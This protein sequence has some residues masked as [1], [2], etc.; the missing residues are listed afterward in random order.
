VLIVLRDECQPSFN[1][2]LEFRAS[3]PQINLEELDKGDRVGPSV[4]VNTRVDVFDIIFVAVIEVKVDQSDLLLQDEW[5]EA[6]AWKVFKGSNV[7]LIH[8]IIT[9][10]LISSR[11]SLYIVQDDHDRANGEFC[12]AFVVHTVQGYCMHSGTV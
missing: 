11:E 10:R 6:I 8:S 7:L 4:F 1:R 12:T 2:P 3:E 5:M 9:S